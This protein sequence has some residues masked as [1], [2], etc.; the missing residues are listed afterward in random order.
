[1]QSKY[2]YDQLDPLLDWLLKKTPRLSQSKVALCT[3]LS[4]RYNLS[5]SSGR[6]LKAEK[7]LVFSYP[8]KVE[9]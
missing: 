6:R 8:G 1:M 5:E 9:L 2:A 3:I 7:S 4:S